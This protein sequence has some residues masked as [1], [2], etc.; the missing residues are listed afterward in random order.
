[1]PSCHS[2]SL[3]PQGNFA[4]YDPLAA[5]TTLVLDGQTLQNLE[6]LENQLDRGVH[7]TLFELLCHCHTAFG[8][9]LFR[10]WLCH[11]LQHI[12]D[13]VARQDAAEDFASHPDL[14]DMLTELLRSLPDLERL[15][16]RVHVGHC[17]LPD[18]LDLLDAVERVAGAA[19]ADLIGTSTVS[20]G[21]LKRLLTVG[22]LFPNLTAPLE[23]VG[24]L[25]DRQA[26]RTTGAVRPR[27]G[28]IPEFDA[29]IAESAR[30]AAEMETELTAA[31]RVLKAEGKKSGAGAVVFWQPSAGKDRY[32]LQ[33]PIALCDRVPASWQLVSSTKNVRRYHSPGVLDAL[34]HFLEAEETQAQ[35]LRTFYQTL[36]LS[37]DEHAAALNAAVAALAEVDCLLSLYTARAAMGD[38]MCRPE[39]VSPVEG[40]DAV[41][42]FVDLRH[43]CVVAADTAGGGGAIGG[44]LTGGATAGASDF[45]PNDTRLGVPETGAPERILLLTG[46]N[47]GGKSTLLRQTCV[48]VILAQLGGWV[49]ATRCR[50]TPVDRIFTRIGANDNIM[51]GRSTFMVELK[52]TATIL[53]KATPQSLVILDELGRGTS[54]FDGYAIAHAVLRHLA[55]ATGC[56]CLFAT[57]YHLLTD[58]FETHAAVANYNMACVVDEAGGSH[59]VTFLYKLQKG[60]CSKSYGMHVAMMAGVEV[61][62]R[63]EREAQSWK[64]RLAWTLGMQEGECRRA[65]W[66]SMTPGRQRTE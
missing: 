26:A 16:S 56:R 9:R 23:A 62:S 52:E 15:L 43:P 29:A 39:F 37:F 18:F 54:T 14:R 22:A 66:D 4:A 35:I 55:D 58:E 44:G 20:S 51:A 25:F 40:A 10:R 1:M 45:I 13:I 61:R 17:R 32:Q 64:K 34:P 50:L 30:R 46:P 3:H 49:P 36:L 59:D 41:L 53:A 42:D 60:V 5:G 24:A 19:N 8:K 47:M 31:R 33:V 21:R 65:G 63:G 28:A 48:A 11:P 12:P 27:R 38:N 57:H 6:V 2:P 7:G